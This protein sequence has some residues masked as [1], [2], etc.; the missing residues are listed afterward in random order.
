MTALG[1][2]TRGA[3]NRYG[4]LFEALGDRQFL[5]IKIDAVWNWNGRDIVQKKLEIPV[6]NDGYF[7]SCTI[8]RRDPDPGGQCPHNV[9][10]RSGANEYAPPDS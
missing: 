1:R 3:D 7:S 9:K 8:A 2:L 10:Y 6:G 5:Q 4:R